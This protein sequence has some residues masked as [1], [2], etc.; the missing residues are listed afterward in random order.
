M[1]RIFLL[2]SLPAIAASILL[3]PVSRSG[4][5][6][7]N[8]SPDFGW[9]VFIDWVALSP[10]P[11]SPTVAFSKATSED[12]SDIFAD[13]V[14]ASPTSTVTPVVFGNDV[15]IDWVALKP[16]LLPTSDIFADWVAVSPATTASPVAFGNDIF[17]DWVA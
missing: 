8:I 2:A 5:T 3:A 7:F 17:V 13:W 10:V 16:N 4:L 1:K 6:A 14:A 11:S 9:D 15:F 12:T